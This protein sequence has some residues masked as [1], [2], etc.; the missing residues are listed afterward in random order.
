MP[1]AGW[2]TAEWVHVAMNNNRR[3]YRVVNGV[4]LKEMLLEDWHSP[5]REALIEELE[6][7][8]VRMNRLRS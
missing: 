5:D 2:M 1:P 6:A 7:R 8:R 3:D 4:K